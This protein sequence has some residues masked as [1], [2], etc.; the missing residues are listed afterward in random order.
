[1]FFCLG[2][3]IEKMVGQVLRLLE[4]EEVTSKGYLIEAD[5]VAILVQQAGPGLVEYLMFGID[6][7]RRDRRWSAAK[8]KAEYVKRMSFCDLKAANYSLPDGGFNGISK[9]LLVQIFGVESHGGGDGFG[10]PIDHDVVE[11]LVQ[12][13]LLGEEPVVCG[14]ALWPIGPCREFLEDVR[15]ETQRRAEIV[16]SITF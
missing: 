12:R 8:E 16:N 14:S 15:C 7:T 5:Q 1:M 3:K 2:D 6:D 9:S 11:Q 10:G 13:E 4:C